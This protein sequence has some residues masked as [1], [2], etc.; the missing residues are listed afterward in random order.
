VRPWLLQRLMLGLLAFDVWVDFLPHGGRYGIGAFNVAHFR[1]LDVL[2]PVPTPALYVGLCVLVGVLAAGLGLGRPTRAGQALLCLLVT[3]SWALSMLDS[4]QHHYLITWLLLVMVGFPRLLATDLFATEVPGSRPLPTQRG[5]GGA[6]FG[7]GL[8]IGL[9]ELAGSDFAFLTLFDLLGE[10]LGRLATMALPLLGALMLWARPA[11]TPKTKAPAPASVPA[12]PVF[13][14]SCAVVYMYTGIAK[15]EADWRS[16]EALGRIAKADLR[17]LAE[18][19]AGEG[20]PVL[21]TMSE[22]EFFHLVARSTIALQFATCVAFVLAAGQDRIASVAKRRLVQLAGL[23][24]LAFHLGAE[25]IGLKIGWFSYYM[26]LVV[27]AVFLP[28]APLRAFAAAAARLHPRRDEA[29]MLWLPVG[30][31]ALVAAGA[32]LDLPGA[33]VAASLA[34][35]GLCGSAALRWR[36]GDG[37]RIGA[38]GRAAVIAAAC[39]VVGVANSEARF[40][41]YRFVGGDHRRR[42]ELEEALVAYE[43]ANRYNLRPHCVTFGRKDV[44]CFGEVFGGEERARAEAAARGPGH[45]YRYR[46]RERQARQVREALDAR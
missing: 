20:L 33:L 10:S 28:A 15:L 14:A 38:W 25:R 45:G 23:A 2:Q 43:K 22:G 46:S 4:Y 26:L 13:C 29:P 6:L 32:L 41:Y 16:G 40:D 44:E 21:G 19:A 31:L 9:L 36:R 3:W 11:E 39:C 34:A 24:P 30:A 42:G 18:L 7:V 27:V 5:V 12:W 37:A 17:A 8:S 35:L 1:W